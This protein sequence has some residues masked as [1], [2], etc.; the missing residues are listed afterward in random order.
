M[1]RRTR[2]SGQF[3]SGYEGKMRMKKKSRFV[4]WKLGLAVCA[5]TL[6]LGT[7][8]VSISAAQSA[9]LTPELETTIVPKPTITPKPTAKPKPTPKPV[10]KGLVKEGRVYP[11]LCKKQK[12]H[13]H[14][15]N[16]K[17]EALLV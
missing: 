1:E 12:G 10:K 8:G 11:L 15:E 6:I 4:P 3:C 16:G 17:W 9:A 5:L 7:G 13:K 14:L 2:I